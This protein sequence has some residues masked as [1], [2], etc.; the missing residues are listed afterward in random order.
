MTAATNDLATSDTRSGRR[1]S[2]F[3]PPIP[4]PNGPEPT[5]WITYSQRPKSRSRIKSNF[6]TWTRLG[7]FTITTLTRHLSLA[8]DA[9]GPKVE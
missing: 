5:Q 9:R 8:V 1:L 7:L 4:Y 3:T 2:W 6:E